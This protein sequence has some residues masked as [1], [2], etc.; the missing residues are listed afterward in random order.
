MKRLKKGF[1]IVSVLFLSL[2]FAQ[3]SD[4]INLLADEYLDFDY[5]EILEATHTYEVKF[6]KGDHVV[7]YTGSITNKMPNSFFLKEEGEAEY[8]YCGIVDISKNDFGIIVTMDIDK[9]NVPYPILEDRSRGDLSSKISVG[10]LNKDG[11]FVGVSGTMDL[12]N[13]KRTKTP[14]TNISGDYASFTL[15]FEG[16]FDLFKLGEETLRGYTG[17]GKVII[18]PYTFK[19]F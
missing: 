13:L 17:K 12:K 7:N 15:E 2:L 6:T 1:H 10:E 8:I 14:H 3:C 4:V 16:E 5:T 11:A 9:Q 19:K 18:S